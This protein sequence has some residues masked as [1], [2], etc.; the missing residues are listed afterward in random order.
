MINKR[1]LDKRITLIIEGKNIYYFKDIYYFKER[2]GNQRNAMRQ[3]EKHILI[4][5]RKYSL[6]L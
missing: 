6:D 1:F 3:L 4:N 2:V 5:E